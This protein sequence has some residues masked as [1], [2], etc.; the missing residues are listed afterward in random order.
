MKFVFFG[1]DFMLDAID[2]LVQD[3]HELIGIMS[4]EC[5]NIFNF[6]KKC[7][8]YAHAR[9]IPFET[10]PANAEHIDKFLKRGCEV[11][12][13]A[14]YPFKIPPVPEDKA[15]AV[16]LHPSLLPKGRSI[17]PTPYIL[18]E[19]PDASGLTI[20]KMTQKFDSGDILHQEKMNLNDDEDVETLTA[21]I[22][23]RAPELLSMVM[24][25]LESYWETAV[26]Q[27]ESKA[28]HWPMPNDNMRTLDWN[29]PAKDLNIMGRAFGRFGVLARYEGQLWV[30]YQFKAWTEKH[31][32]DPGTVTCRLSRETVV[33]C[34][35]GYVCLKE[36]QKL[37]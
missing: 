2:R 13:A 8:A 27:D 26:P 34:A 21:R 23:M 1:Y 22:A 36:T 10:N 4:F 20:H 6:N 12:L 32:Y 16:N 28:D 17:M 24:A 15:Y 29:K 14:G 30:V 7:M 3:G 11:F 25:D 37:S 35:D 18:T 9:S 5:D 19:H 31:D 33:A